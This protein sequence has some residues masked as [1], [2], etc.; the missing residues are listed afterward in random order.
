M[1]LMHRHVAFDLGFELRHVLAAGHQV[2]DLLTTLLSL[3]K[4]G[5]LRT[6]NEDREMISN[7]EGMDD[8]V[9]NEDDR[10]VLLASLQDYPQDVS[11]FFDPERS[12]G[13]VEDQNGC[14]K[15]HGAGDRKGL[16]LPAR[17]TADEAVSVFDARDPELSRLFD[18]DLVGEFAI[19]YGKGPAAL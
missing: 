16:A 6:F 10:D 3:A 2:S 7:G 15:M 8:V 1:A 18:R 17:E 19:I 12:R 4:I 5:G 14:A 13:L 11:R 9:G